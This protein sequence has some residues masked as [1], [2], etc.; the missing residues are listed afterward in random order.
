MY[1]RYW[2]HMPPRHKIVAHYGV[3]NHRYKLIY[4]YGEALGSSGTLDIGVPPEWDLYDLELDPTEH[5][6][7][8]SDPAY[9]D[10]VAS[11]TAEIERTG[12]T[13]ARDGRHKLIYFGDELTKMGAR[14]SSFA[15]EWELFDLEAD[16]QEMNN[17]YSDPVYADVV[18][19]MTAELDRLQAAVG[20]VGR[21]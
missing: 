11:L 10:V 12:V 1:Y 8:Y 14:G 7:V 15:R 13:V 17:V 4:Y 5:E 16:P 18:V 19:E 21:H 6:S 20:D 9:A 3:R 2:M